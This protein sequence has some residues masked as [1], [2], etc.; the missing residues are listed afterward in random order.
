MFMGQNL[1]KNPFM[2]SKKPN[3]ENMINYILS[4]CLWA[5]ISQRIH[6]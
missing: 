4:T 6:L 1:T 5:K 2:T 3:V